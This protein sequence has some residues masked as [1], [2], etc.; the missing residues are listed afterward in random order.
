M[1]I[2]TSLAAGLIADEHAVNQLVVQPVTQESI[3]LLVSTVV[4]TMDH[5]Y[6]LPII[7]SDPSA[8]WTAEGA[9]ITPSDQGFDELEV[10]PKKLAALTI[11]SNE[12]AADSNPSA[13]KTVGDGIVRD[14]AKKLDSAYFGN[15]VTNGPSGLLSVAGVSAVDTG[16]TGVFP[17]NESSVF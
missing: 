12:L 16:G 6:R 13:Q 1:A 11:I 7:T 4:T 10:V 14:L 8:A 15:T 17:V 2:D 5:S 3:G 9:E